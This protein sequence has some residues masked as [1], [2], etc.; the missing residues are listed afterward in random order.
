MFMSTLTTHTDAGG[1]ARVRSRAEF[2]LVHQKSVFQTRLPESLRKARPIRRIRIVIC[3][4]CSGCTIP[5]AENLQGISTEIPDRLEF[6][7]KPVISRA[8]KHTAVPAAP[9][10]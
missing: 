3:S 4:D 6:G 2:G 1:G 7:F 10:H 9:P 8:A 5:Y